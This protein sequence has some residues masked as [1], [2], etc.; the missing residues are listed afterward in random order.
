MKCG[1][2]VV[3]VVASVFI[4]NKMN[5]LG[6]MFAFVRFIKVSNQETLIN[7][8]CNIQV[9][10]LRLHANKTRFFRE[11]KKPKVDPP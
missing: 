4:A 3:G 10:N 6:Q 5:K 9:E 7:S 11:A 1:T 8:L 2:F